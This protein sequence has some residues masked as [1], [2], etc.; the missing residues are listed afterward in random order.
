MVGNGYRLVAPLV[1]LPY[2]RVGRGNRVLCGHIGVA[3]QLNALF[4]LVLVLFGIFLQKRHG[5][6]LYNE[7]LFVI[8]KFIRAVYK[9]K[10]A[11]L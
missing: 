11:V 5:A 6:R 8:I 7:I 9:D 10:S 2:N 1:G 3:V 4:A